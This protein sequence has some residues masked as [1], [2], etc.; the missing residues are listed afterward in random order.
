MPAVGNPQ[1]QT[2][3]DKIV[4]ERTASIFYRFVNVLSKS[5][6]KIF[7]WNRTCAKI[8]TTCAIVTFFSRTFKKI[9]FFATVRL[10]RQKN[11]FGHMVPPLL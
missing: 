5:W 9:K 7:L 11:S 8:L 1:L 3:S 10:F 4:L 6:K 2:I